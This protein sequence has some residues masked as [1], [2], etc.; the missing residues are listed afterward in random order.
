MR[1][2][3]LQ[4]A[5]A[6]PHRGA[7][8][9]SSGMSYGR[10]LRVT[11]TA[12]SMAGLG[13]SMAILGLCVGVFLGFL[14]WKRRIGLP[15]YLTPWQQLFTANPDSYGFVGLQQSE[16]NSSWNFHY[17]HKKVHLLGAYFWSFKNSGLGISNNSFWK[18]RFPNMKISFATRE[19]TGCGGYLLKMGKFLWETAAV[20]FKV[21]G[22]KNEASKGKF[23]L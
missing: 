1:R 12:G 18:N 3:S 9:R 23:S 11:Y 8:G 21:S 22:W 10:F 14:L 7:D 13:F 2:H 4:L 17:R 15:Y 6:S 19:L 20:S 5:T 16:W